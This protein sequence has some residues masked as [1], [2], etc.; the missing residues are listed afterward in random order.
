MPAASRQQDGP[1]PTWLAPVGFLEP[2][3]FLVLHTGD[4][5]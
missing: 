5:N 4:V 3:G 1:P 2:A